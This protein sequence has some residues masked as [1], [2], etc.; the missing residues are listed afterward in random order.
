MNN[1]L[2]IS[3]SDCRYD[4][5]LRE[6]LKIAQNIGNLY[7]VV[8]FQENCDE[9]NIS[10][11]NN[12]SVFEFIKKTMKLA[13][14]MSS[15]DIIF[16]DNRM[17]CIPGLILHRKYPK[18]Q[19]IQD[20]REL[21]V[22][23][24][25]KRLKSKIGC[26]VE[27]KMYKH[28]DVMICAN[29]YR[30]QIMKGSYGLLEEPLV[31]ENVRK[32]NYSSEVNLDIF[33]EKYKDIFSR[34]TRKIISTSGWDVSRTNDKLVEAMESFPNHDLLMVGGGS[35]NDKVIIQ[36]IVQ[37]KQLTNVFFIGKVVEDELKYLL[38]NCHIGIVNYG[39]YDTNNRFCA[40]GKIYEYLFEGCPVVTTENIP[41]VEFCKENGVGE[42]DDNYV[43]AIK[44][45]TDN[46]ELY[47][48]NIKRYEK[49]D[50]EENNYRIKEK[51]KGKLGIK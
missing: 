18:A 5:R 33:I 20:V 31:Y 37:E 48:R 1:I 22:L 9:K 34:N 14:N 6:L 49:L 51:I 11:S 38:S 3:F 32:L 8:R 45:V 17:A 41:L 13:K 29:K 50:V 35:E 15:V 27:Q 25:Q 23:S 7:S 24:E 26:Y 10:L 30:A 2:F 36:N 19:I 42:S 39:K 40:S 43:S 4:G 46:Y 44:K 47:K 28:A 21:Y 12:G 16:I